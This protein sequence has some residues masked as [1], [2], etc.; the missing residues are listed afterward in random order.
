ML[1]F[2]QKH[3]SVV[4]LDTIANLEK[5]VNNSEQVQYIKQTIAIRL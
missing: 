5:E 1:A 4:A 3:G 2:S